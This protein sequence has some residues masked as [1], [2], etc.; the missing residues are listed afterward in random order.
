MTAQLLQNGFGGLQDALTNFQKTKQDAASSTY[1]AQISKYTDPASLNA[2]LQSG[3]IDTRGVSA[4]AL[5]F[6]LGRESSLLANDNQ[7][8][9]NDRAKFGNTTA[10][11][12]DQLAQARLA[13]QPQAAKLLADVQTLAGSGDP[14]KVEQARAMIANGNQTLLDAGYKA[15][16]IPGLIDAARSTG[17][18][19][20]GYKKDVLANDQFWEN[21]GVTKTARD[22]AFKQING[23]VTPEMAVRAIQ[24]DN[25]IS[26]PRIKAQAIEVINQA[27]DQKVFKTPDAATQL[28]TSL[29]VQTDVPQTSGQGNGPT[30]G[31]LVD[32]TEG[33]ANYSTL[34]AHAQKDGGAFAGVDV[35][36]QTIGQLKQFA[37]SDGAYG[38]HQKNQLGYLATPMGR[39]QIVGQTMVNTAKEMGLPDDT[40]FSADVQDAMFN[41]I[42]DKAI[43]GPKSMAGKMSALR[44]QWEGFKNVKDD[45]LS[46]AI[47]NYEKGDRSALGGI[48]NGQSTPN[49]S[50]PTVINAGAFPRGGQDVINQLLG[51][52]PIG[53][54]ANGPVSVTDGGSINAGAFPPGN[55]LAELSRPQISLPVGGFSTDTAVSDP[56]QTPAQQ[57][58]AAVDP[59]AAAPAV[60]AGSL[61]GSLVGGA[62]AAPANTSPAAQL[63]QAAAPAPV[64]NTDSPGTAAQKLL[65]QGTMDQAFNADAPLIAQIQQAQ[66][67]TES[68]NQVMK[69][70]VSPGGAL[71]G[72]N[73]QAV[74]EALNQTMQASGN[75]LKPAAAGALIAQNPVS[76]DLQATIDKVP[77]LG[78]IIPDSWFS[79]DRF[80]APENGTS[81]RRI[82]MEGVQKDLNK[83]GF[84]VDGS[85]KLGR[86]AA[87]ISNQ[88]QAVISTQQVTAIQAAVLQNSVQIAQIQQAIQ[89]GNKD[90]QLFNELARL[91]D[92]QAKFNALLQSVG[93]EPGSPTTI[94]SGAGESIRPQ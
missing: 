10:V 44:G 40:V 59:T 94:F 57:L 29:N 22:L 89:S 48:T 50:A 62:Q 28:L 13:A 75:K 60:S 6:G 85:I 12:D 68:I 64:A 49:A 24:N 36:K 7:Q 32:K 46:A 20:F 86:G 72:M 43:S 17:T 15:D 33:G 87:A 84:N 31:G 2:A 42:A 88:R 37:S 19:G 52:Q 39:Y 73:E 79:G 66:S 74:L 25:T 47:T 27:A 81:A 9:V 18:A 26:D 69:K 82:D 71:E 23:S 67:S 51:S 58:A 5:K 41:H 21:Q 14:A 80:G 55:S 53:G 76:K 35:S 61:V 16:A 30:I 65:D 92:Q 3:A 45:V 4:D 56:V 63:A 83:I 78:S 70:L 93:Q 34:Y 77:I 1:L 91:Q 54:T 90:P 8:L 11:R 38:Q